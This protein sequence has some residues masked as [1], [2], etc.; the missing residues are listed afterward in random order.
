MPA[1]ERQTAFQDLGQWKAYM[2]TVKAQFSDRDPDFYCNRNA[3]SK[4]TQIK[5]VLSNASVY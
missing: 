2:N 1:A 5:R 3:M 4:Q